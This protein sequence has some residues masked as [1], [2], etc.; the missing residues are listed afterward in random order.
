MLYINFLWHY[1]GAEPNENYLTRFASICALCVAWFP[2]N[3]IFGR[4][5]NK[6]YIYNMTDFYEF[7][8]PSVSR[9]EFESFIHYI[10]AGF[11]FLS[12]G[13]LA[14]IYFAKS[15][16]NGD[17]LKWRVHTYKTCGIGIIISIL[18]IIAISILFDDE[19]S[20]AFPAT[21]TLETIALAF[22]GAAWLIKGKTEK[23][24]SIKI[25]QEKISQTISK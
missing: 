7:V 24:K 10:A 22:F 15:E 6:D 20:W 16:K 11:F 14:L 21:F 23:L 4:I 8:P 19:E 1:K 3:I 5:I 9:P 25:L 17:N 12:L 18:S 2:T 13:I